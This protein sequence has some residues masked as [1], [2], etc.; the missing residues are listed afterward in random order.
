MVVTFMIITDMYSSE[1]FIK[2]MEM[3]FSVFIISLIL[4]FGGFGEFE[5]FLQPEC[6]E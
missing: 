1:Y 4:T 6:E 3:F 5:T 2:A